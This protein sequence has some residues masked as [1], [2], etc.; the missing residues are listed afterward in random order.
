MKCRE[1]GTEWVHLDCEE[2]KNT[3]AFVVKCP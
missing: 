3:M 2:E 1:N